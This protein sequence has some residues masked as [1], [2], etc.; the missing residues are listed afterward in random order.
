MAMEMAMEERKRRE[1]QLSVS[2]EEKKITQSKIKKCLCHTSAHTCTHRDITDIGMMS[3][4]RF[5]RPCLLHQRRWMDPMNDRGRNKTGP[6][7]MVLLCICVCARLVLSA[8]CLPYR[9]MHQGPGSQE[10]ERMPHSVPN[11]LDQITLASDCW[12]EQTDIQTQ[13]HTE[14]H[15]DTET[16]RHRETTRVSQLPFP[17]KRAYLLFFFF[18]PLCSPSRHIVMDSRVFAILSQNPASAVDRAVLFYSH[19]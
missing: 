18:C 16:H 9:T 12:R 14:A 10:P 13:R 1:V 4:R 8:S 19:D 7:N 17:N 11:N 2:G 6:L 3:L 15:R 5:L